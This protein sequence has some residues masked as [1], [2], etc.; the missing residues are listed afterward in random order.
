MN[1][2]YNYDKSCFTLKE[3]GNSKKVFETHSY[4]GFHSSETIEEGRFKLEIH[5]NIYP[6]NP[7]KAFLRA[8]VFVDGIK[9]L[10]VSESFRIPVSQ[11]H[12]NLHEISFTQYGAGNNN[13]KEPSTVFMRKDLDWNNLLESICTVSEQPVEWQRRQFHLL[14]AKL[15]EKESFKRTPALLVRLLEIYAPYEKLLGNELYYKLRP[16]SI[17]IM[18]VL[19]DKI[20]REGTGLDNNDCFK[21]GDLIWKCIKN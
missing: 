18:R 16:Y 11:V 8:N 12:F 17:G 7:Q 10:P 2:Y 20:E 4:E 14:L 5:T 15:E 1:L 13:G 3:D 6:K 21:Y 9:L 19:L